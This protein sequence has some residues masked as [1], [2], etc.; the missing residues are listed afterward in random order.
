MQTLMIDPGN[1]AAP[2]GAAIA[3][4]LK[5]M[6]LSFTQARRCITRRVWTAFTAQRQQ[7]RHQ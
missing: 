5:G 6:A 7:L 1:A 3:L 2:G 4:W